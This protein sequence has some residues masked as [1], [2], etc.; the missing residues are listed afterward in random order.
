MGFRSTNIASRRVLALTLLA[1]L[2]F[3]ACTFSLADIPGLNSSTATPGLPGPTATP[4]SL[5]IWPTVR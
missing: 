3:N 5:A 2:L 1:L 4:Q